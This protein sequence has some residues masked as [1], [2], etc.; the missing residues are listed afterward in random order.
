MTDTAT[1]YDQVPY[2]FYSFPESQPRRL[3]AVAHLFGL[4]TPAPAECRVLELGCAVG[5][6]IVP[7]AYSLPKATLIGI[8]LAASQIETARKF[9]EASG[10]K[11][12]D[13]RAAN[14]S[15]VTRS[16]GSSITSSRT[17]C[18]RGFHTTWR[19]RCCRSAEQLTPNG[20]GLHQLEKARAGRDFILALAQS[21][22][23]SALLKGQVQY[24]QRAG[25]GMSRFEHSRGRLVTGAG[26]LHDAL[27]TIS[28][29][30]PQAISIKEV[31][32]V[33]GQ[34]RAT[35]LGELLNC[36]MNGMLELYVDPP[37]VLAQAPGTNRARA[38]SRAIEGWLESVRV[39]YH[40]APVVLAVQFSEEFAPLKHA[41]INAVAIHRLPKV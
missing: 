37:A 29:R 12:L 14:I 5:G 3:Q 21:P 28:R 38:S 32:D 18:S 39:R 20:L 10:V 2:I 26:P 15:D 16:G 24:L 31:I 30:F 4:Q 25:N 34:Y 36:W 11:N 1:S 7:M 19:R 8:D 22:F 23:A 17:A 13:L 27:V 6:N 35:L 9:A 40:L 33:A 41:Q